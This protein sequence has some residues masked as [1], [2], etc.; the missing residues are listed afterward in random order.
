MCL[1]CT[2]GRDERVAREAVVQRVHKGATFF[3]TDKP[4]WFRRLDLDK[5]RP[6]NE[7]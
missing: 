2:A 6:P 1:A 3:D 4:D 5:L 7:S